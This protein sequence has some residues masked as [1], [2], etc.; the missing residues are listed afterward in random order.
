MSVFCEDNG[1]LFGSSVIPK[2]RASLE[3]ITINRG[4]KALRKCISNLEVRRKTRAHPA[5]L[6]GELRSHLPTSSEGR[7]GKGALQDFLVTTQQGTDS[8]K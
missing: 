3:I 6:T 5:P 4:R 7:P 1:G 2:E 8:T